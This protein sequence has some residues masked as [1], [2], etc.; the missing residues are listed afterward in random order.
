MFR[1]SEALVNWEEREGR[2]GLTLFSY[3]EIRWTN[4][5]DELVKSRISVGIRF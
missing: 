5:D 2:L 1:S 4:Q 3:R